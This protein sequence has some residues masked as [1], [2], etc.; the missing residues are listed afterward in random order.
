MFS[1]LIMLRNRSHL[2]G[3]SRLRGGNREESLGNTEN[4]KGGLSCDAKEAFQDGGEV[5]TSAHCASTIGI[6]CVGRCM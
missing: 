5:N 1:S 3:C 2:D 4:L 6:H